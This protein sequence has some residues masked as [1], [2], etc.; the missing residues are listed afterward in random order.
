[1][2]LLAAL[3]Y[4]PCELIGPSDTNLKKK[5]N[6]ASLIYA[7][8]SFRS[9]LFH[10][11]ALVTLLELSQAIFLQMRHRNPALTRPGWCE[12]FRL[13]LTSCCVPNSF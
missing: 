5:K 11:I 9:N 8:F 4:E 7:S 3:V 1:M 2:T 10:L 13:E 6:I 12:Q